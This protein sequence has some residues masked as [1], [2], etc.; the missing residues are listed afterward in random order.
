MSSNLPLGAENDPNAPYNMV[1]YQVDVQFHG[2]ISYVMEFPKGT[3][4]EV[5]KDKAIDWYRGDI[6]DNCTDCDFDELS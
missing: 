1:E 5:I 6:V 3:P 2:L 4:E